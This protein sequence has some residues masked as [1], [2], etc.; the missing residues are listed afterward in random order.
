M[1]GCSYPK[2]PF[3]HRVV[4]S[5]RCVEMGSDLSEL[6]QQKGQSGLNLGEI[7]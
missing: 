7:K 2:Q 6:T 1:K 3:M 4:S 5:V